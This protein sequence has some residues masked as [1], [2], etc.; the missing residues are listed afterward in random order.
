MARLA[1]C[2]QQLAQANAWQAEIRKPLRAELDGLRDAM[3]GI[4]T[5]VD[6]LG[7]R[8]ADN[9]TLR[10][11]SKEVA[12]TVAMLQEEAV[13]DREGFER[14]LEQTQVQLGTKADRSE[15]SRIR[16]QIG[17]RPESQQ[18]SNAG[19][20]RAVL[21]RLLGSGTRV[22]RMLGSSS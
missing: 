17:S 18:D 1:R 8:A 11:W 5:I 14:R 4:A 7:A 22:D 19:A 20:D 15:M 10:G 9:D 2:E 12:S 16:A 6:A 3:S 13:N 21:M